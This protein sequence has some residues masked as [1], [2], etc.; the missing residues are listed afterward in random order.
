MEMDSKKHVRSL[1]VS[2][3][4]HDRVL[5]DVNMGELI[6]LTVEDGRVLEVKGTHGILR[7]DLAIEELEAMLSHMRKNADPK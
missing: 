4:V 7:V 2:D 1:I 3:D 6:G 5:F